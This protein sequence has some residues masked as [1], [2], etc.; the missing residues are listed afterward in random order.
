MAH[1]G[2]L[3]D[4][5]IQLLRQWR[6]YTCAQ[7][8]ATVFLV[9]VLRQMG[10]SHSSLSESSSESVNSSSTSGWCAIFST[11]RVAA[12]AE[13][14][15]PMYFCFKSREKKYIFFHTFGEAVANISCAV[16]MN[17]ELEAAARNE[18]LNLITTR[19]KHGRL[20]SYMLWRPSDID[21]A[22]AHEFWEEVKSESD[23][24]WGTTTSAQTTGR[25]TERESNVN[26]PTLDTFAD[27]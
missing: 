3:L 12:C 2:Q 22:T 14:Q 4:F 21:M 15:H 9:L 20:R 11:T 19:K 10:H 16:Q 8:V 25:C 24:T 13:Q 18:Y 23:G 7:G 17:E 5:N 26:T 27:A 6:W 1:I